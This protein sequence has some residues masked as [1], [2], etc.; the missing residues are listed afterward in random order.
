[1]RFALAVVVTLL[2]AAPA[3]AQSPS[4]VTFANSFPMS[5]FT[6]SGATFDGECGADRIAKGGRD[7]GPYLYLECGLPTITF[8]QPQA[9]VELFVRMPAGDTA[10]FSACDGETCDLALQQVNSRGEWTTVV[11]AAAGIQRV[12]ANPGAA[13]TNVMELDDVSFS[14]TAEQ[15]DTQI[16]GAAPPFTLTSSHPLGGTF[17]CMIDAKPATPC[18]SPFTPVGL[19][20]GT[21]TMSATAIDV[22]DRR[23]PTPATTTFTTPVAIA[24]PVAVADADGDGVPDASDN[25]P[26]AA[27]A[28]QADADADGVGDACEQLPP[29]NVP[30]VAGVTAVVKQLSGEVYVKLPSRIPFQAGGFIP[31]KGVA[32]VPVGSTVDTR[33]GEIE[34][35]SAANGY[36]AKDRRAKRQ[37]A[38]I[39]AGM[40]VI[41]QK[42]A[43]KKVAKKTAIGTDIGLLSP[44]GAEAA[45]AKGPAKGIVRSV[46]LVAK[47]LFRTLGGASTATAKN[48][49]FNTTDRCD[50]TVTEVGRGRVTIAV[51]GS[52][53]RVVVRS[54]GA[55]LAKAKLF[56]IKKGKRP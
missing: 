38:R 51:R 22:Y 47:G 27:N 23:D 8:Q 52:K 33:K 19:A 2:V 21:H 45:C 31:L 41:K 7:G 25:C 53:K 44:P 48:A 5:P 26:A 6:E 9:L 20:P 55:Y 50:G 46:S 16:G 3:S 32:S 4:V 39:K 10:S 29:G 56:R 14:T 17:L 36:A 11:L 1:M 43:K 15:P 30:P 34:L 24:P 12:I 37:S 54:G 42:R 49:T 28:S 40:F 18:A 13:S 35:D